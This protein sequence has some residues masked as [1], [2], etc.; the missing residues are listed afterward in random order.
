MRTRRILVLAGVLCLGLGVATRGHGDEPARGSKTALDE[1]I[2]K[3]DPTYAWKVVST[4]PGD[5]Y[6]TFVVDLKS[7]SWRSVPEVDRAVWQHWLVIVKPELVRHDTAFLT[8]GGGKNGSQAPTAPNPQMV[9]VAKTTNSVVAELRMI[10]NQPLIFNGDGQPRSED[11][12]IAYCWVK[13]MDTGDATWLPRLPW[14]RVS[15]GRWT[16]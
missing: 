1:Y 13:Y 11:D 2:A 7:Q 9:H 5:G 15:C 3:P 12:L 16:R 4:I 6:T 10:P 14:S 8:I